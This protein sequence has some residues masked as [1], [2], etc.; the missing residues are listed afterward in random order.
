MPRD[1]TFSYY[2]SKT[3]TQTQPYTKPWDEWIPVLTTHDVRENK[4]G[5]ALVFAEIEGPR[6]LANVKTVNALSL[7]LDE[8]PP[9]IVESILKTLSDFEYV[10]YTT[11]RH[12]STTV[13]YPRIRVVLPL[14][15]PLPPSEFPGAWA[16]LN[17]HIG[18][19]ND[20][21]TKDASRLNYLPST[22][23]ESLALSEH[24]SGKWL[25]PEDLFTT[26]T[27]SNNIED[28]HEQNTISDTAS[29]MFNSLRGLQTTHDL[30]EQAMAL[31]RGES[32]AEAPER[33]KTILKLTIFLAGK[34]PH[35]SPETI[36]TVFSR[37]IEV[38]STQPDP[39]TLKEVEDAFVGAQKK[40]LEKFQGSFSAYSKA[41]LETIAQKQG[42]N[43]EDLEERWII[44]KEGGGWV[45][46]RNG[47]Y[48][49]FFSYRDFPVAIRKH[50]AS[51]PIEL[52][53]PTQN[54]YK[55]RSVEDL[56]TLYGDIAQSVISDLTKQY[57]VFDAKTRTIIE[58]VSPLR[59]LEPKYDKQ[60]DEW[61]Y[62]L[63]GDNYNKGVDWMATVSDL[64]KP[65]CAIYFVGP[66]DSGKTMLAI[67]LSKLWTT[68][69]PGKLSL[70]LD[71]KNEEM[72]RCPLIL[73]DETLPRKYIHQ[74]V[75]AELRSMLSTTTRTLRRL[76]QPPSELE[77]AIRLI[78][79][80]NND[81]LL[82][83][84]EIHTAEDLEAIAQRFMYVQV[85]TAAP[86]YLQNI[87]RET[88]WMWM[89]EGIARHALWLAQNHVVKN[90]GNRFIVEG[91]I[92]EMHRLLL[93]GAPWSSLVC[94]WLVR[95]LLNPKPFDGECNGLIRRGDGKLWVNNQALVTSWDLYLKHSKEK[96]DARKIGTSLN[97]ICLDPKKRKQMRWGN[98]K[99]W[100]KEVDVAH[101]RHW[102]TEYNIGDEDTILK[103]LNS[104]VVDSNVGGDVVAMKRGGREE[105]KE[106][107]DEGFEW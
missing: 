28:L 5:P 95:Y 107:H 15:A 12:G 106:K 77:G 57:T 11:H 56:S 78:L 62:H 46:D 21:Q 100:Y 88:T 40:H 80:A 65:L 85:P 7:D 38:M 75:T 25:A 32:F 96:A 76:Y 94:E 23:D 68:G 91:D 74:S 14:E 64:T 61:L 1:L 20:K 82:N 71:D 53:E 81:S 54:G 35:A 37:S 31:Y 2:E 10:V 63:F 72:V 36:R 79:A 101:L 22:F 33:H 34:Y 103:T 41:E 87:P 55:R 26:G 93:I 66:K 4:D 51:A 18:G 43:S 27:V 9:E 13:K 47:N 60:I 49:G 97:T 102:M 6:L 99:I 58:S 50:L 90:P 83:T 69:A 8:S 67:G 98:R 17:K 104:D 29:K 73:A 105:R 52:L 16:R 86:E 89:Q 42:C 19:H 70:V 39:P 30:K 59:D 44:Q 84:N 45:L 48:Q 3:D 92:A 24:H